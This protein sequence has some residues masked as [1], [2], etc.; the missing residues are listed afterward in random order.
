MLPIPRSRS[1]NVRTAW[2]RD[3]VVSGTALDFGIGQ[4]P[5][6]RSLALR[7]IHLQVVH[8]HQT[9]PLDFQINEGV[10]RDEPGGVI[11]V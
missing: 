3:T 7:P 5:V 1:H 9:L 10:W 11:E 6:H 4:H 2:S 8:D